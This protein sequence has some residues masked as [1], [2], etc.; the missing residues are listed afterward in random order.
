MGVNILVEA[1][2]Q[3]RVALLVTGSRRPSV[4]ERWLLTSVSS[5]LAAIAPYPMVV[6]PPLVP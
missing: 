4:M 3:T 2:V 6:V 5:D 1:R